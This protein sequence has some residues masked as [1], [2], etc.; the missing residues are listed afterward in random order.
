MKPEL[1]GSLPKTTLKRKASDGDGEPSE[2][3]PDGDTDTGLTVSFR[4]T[5]LKLVTNKLLVL[6][7]RCVNGWVDLILN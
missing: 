4:C 2:M 3:R 6:Q 1:N 7:G 5:K